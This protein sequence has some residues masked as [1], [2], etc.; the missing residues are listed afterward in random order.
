MALKLP[1]RPQTLCFPAPAQ[2]PLA[3]APALFLAGRGPSR[4]AGPSSPSSS[5]PGSTSQKALTCR[6]EQ[7]ERSGPGPLAVPREDERG[8]KALGL[9]SGGFVPRG[10]LSTALA[11]R[12]GE[13]GNLNEFMSHKKP[14]GRQTPSSLAVSY[15]Q[16]G[17]GGVLRSLTHGL[18]SLR[19][20]LRSWRPMAPST[21]VPPALL[22]LV[23]LL[24]SGALLFQ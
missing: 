19:E 18:A 9:R 5:S 16:A 4:A 22:L 15:S 8:S 21:Q 7:T 20:H 10:Q 24:L 3:L 6:A 23:A 2:A 12:W 14:V 1:G 17:V 11:S 13:T